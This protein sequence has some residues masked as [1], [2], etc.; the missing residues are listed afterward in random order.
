[1]DA[2]RRIYID[3][4]R[5]WVPSQHAKGR[6][7]DGTTYLSV[8]ARINLNPK[9]LWFGPVSYWWPNPP[10]PRLDHPARP[11]RGSST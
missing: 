2:S 11:M 3:E 10:P 1:M 5:Y 4:M 8:A 9:G 6:T 7:E